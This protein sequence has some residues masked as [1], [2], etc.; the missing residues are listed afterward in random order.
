MKKYLKMLATLFTLAVIGSALFSSS[1]FAECG[2]S[3]SSKQ[4]LIEYAKSNPTWVHGF[5]KELLKHKAYTGY[6]AD[7]TVINYLESPE[8]QVFA[9]PTGYKLSTNTFCPG[10][11]G[12]YKPYERGNPSNALLGNMSGK[13]MLWHCDKEGHNCV[14][15][16][17]GYCVNFVTGKPC[18]PH[19]PPK[20]KARKPKPCGCHHKH[21]KPHKKKP[22]PKCS[23]KSPN[24]GGGN[25]S[26]TTVTVTP[27]QECEASDHSSASCSQPVTV[28]TVGAC[29]NYSSG[30]SGD[31]NQGGNCNN[32]GTETCVGQNNCSPHEEETCVNNS[33]NE[34]PP[35]PKE[36]CGCTP[37]PPP[38]CEDHSATNYKGPLP[39]KYPPP[40]VAPKVELE[41]LNDFEANEQTVICARV[42]AP[43]GDSL[44]VTFY[45]GTSSFANHGEGKLRA[46]SSN[47]WCDTLTVSSEPG[48]AHLKVVVMDNTTH[49]SAED[50]KSAPINAEKF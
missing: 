5:R 29:S 14:P 21:H 22:A 35:P 3:F 7:E 37:P 9:A 34:T 27:K 4:E 11:P 46:G 36:E 25:C 20:H 30:N 49:L 18:K 10:G 12:K 19:A 23:T 50:A 6:Q 44:T 16:L 42:T 24:G 39:C 40:P 38:V 8:Q 26:P 28:I 32:G 13:A 41:E 47:E 48:T 33:C 17:K 2:A 1:A 45:G 43:S 15:L 31:T